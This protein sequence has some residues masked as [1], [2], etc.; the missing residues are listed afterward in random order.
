[1]KLSFALILLPLASAKVPLLTE[2]NFHEKTAGK[3][4]FIKFFAPWV[5]L[6]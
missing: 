5:R 2:D 3:S 4:V 1:M 6:N